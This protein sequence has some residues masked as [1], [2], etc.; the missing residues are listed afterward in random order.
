MNII[1]NQDISVLAFNYNQHFTPENVQTLTEKLFSKRY[2]YEQKYV[3]KLGKE[4]IL[5]HL[6]QEAL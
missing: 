4:G 1:Q 3:K 5:E 2:T 6:F